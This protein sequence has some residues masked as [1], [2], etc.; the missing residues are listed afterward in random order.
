MNK[1]EAL[2]Y[3]ND[4]FEHDVM[5][6]VYEMRGSDEACRRYMKELERKDAHKDKE[7]K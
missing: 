5:E 4:M 6:K 7:D 2:E 1:Q 3:Y